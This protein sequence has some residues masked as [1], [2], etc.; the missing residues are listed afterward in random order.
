MSFVA[1]VELRFCLCHGEKLVQSISVALMSSHGMAIA[2]FRM[3]K[4]VSTTVSYA[5][6]V[7]RRE[8]LVLAEKENMQF[9]KVFDLVH[10]VP[11]TCTN[12]SAAKLLSRRRTSYDSSFRVVRANYY[13]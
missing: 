5:G 6:T 4:S 1:S 12:L 11:P 8:V 9:Q 3:L 13:A 2:C 10:G 7:L